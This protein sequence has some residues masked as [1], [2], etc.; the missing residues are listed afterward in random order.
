M[1]EEA[2]SLQERR[3]PPSAVVIF[4]ASGDLTERKLVP[5][6]VNLVRHRRVA[7]SLTLIGVGRT[8]LSDEEFR[9]RVA[10]D[11]Q[12]LAA[13]ELAGDVQYL[14]GSYDHLGTYRRL[15]E[16]LGSAPGSRRNRLFYGVLLRGHVPRRIPGSL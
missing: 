8:A 7:G 15:A 12:A 13:A 10:F 4:G 1:T 2:A 11:P 16:L 5:A 3:A 6:L 9:E 14:S